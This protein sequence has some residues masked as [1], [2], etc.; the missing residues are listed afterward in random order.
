MKITVGELRKIIREE[1]FP[2]P[3][4]V[5]GHEISRQL[6]GTSGQDK[7]ERILDDLVKNYYEI[8]QCNPSLLD[9]A[10]AANTQKAGAGPILQKWGPLLVF[11]MKKSPIRGSQNRTFYHEFLEEKIDNDDA[12]DSLMKSVDWDKV[13][14]L[15]VQLSDTPSLLSDRARR[16]LDSFRSDAERKLYQLIVHLP[17]ARNIV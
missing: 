11:G 7:A 3:V 4:R 1:A 17:S 12:V 13:S 6:D 15:V 8:A 5:A 14:S 2:E 16:G 10:K 9:A